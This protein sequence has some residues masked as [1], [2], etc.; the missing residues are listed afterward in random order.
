VTDR[1]IID[2]LRLGVPPAV[3][4]LIVFALLRFPP[5]RYSFYPQ[6]PVYELLHIQCPGC[7]GTRAVAAVLQGQFSQA[8]HHN[9]LVILLFPVAA[10]YGFLSYCRFARR[11][12]LRWPHPPAGAIYAAFVLTAVFTVMRNLPL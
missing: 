8:M 10:V 2:T 12:P 5:A 1:R 3:A 6:C 4:G 11:K 9:A 7:G